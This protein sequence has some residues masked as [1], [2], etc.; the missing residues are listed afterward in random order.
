MMTELLTRWWRK[1][2]PH[3]RRIAKK[4]ELERILALNGIATKHAAKIANRVYAKVKV[5]HDH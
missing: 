1:L 5:D 2:S 3:H 4:R